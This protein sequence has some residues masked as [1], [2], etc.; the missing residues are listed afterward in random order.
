MGATFLS[1]VENLP[2]EGNILING[3]LNTFLILLYGV[4]FAWGVF[5]AGLN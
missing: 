4:G 3:A 1:L 5:I 2:E